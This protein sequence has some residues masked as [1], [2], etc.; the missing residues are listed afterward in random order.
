MTFLT[1]FA[2]SGY[3]K[4][5]HGGG[6]FGFS[7]HNSFY[8]DKNV[9]IYSASNGNDGN[10]HEVL[11]NHIADLALGLQPILNDTTLCTFP[12]PWGGDSKDQEDPRKHRTNHKQRKESRRHRPYNEIR[13]PVMDNDV[14][15]TPS[16]QWHEPFVGTF[17]HKTFGNMTVFYNSG[18]PN[19]L[20]YT[21]GRFG[22]GTLTRRG[23][24]TFNIIYGGMLSYSSTD[25]TL[26]F[27]KEEG[28]LYQEL[29]HQDYQWDRPPVFTRGLQWDPR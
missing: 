21:I 22:E 10:L 26:W 14:I 13:E 19:V 5:S 25:S 23:P 27:Q 20:Q 11:H 4:Y 17:G 9:G 1:F 24:V 8:P 2:F 6:W 18:D 15:K 12:R 29:V 16:L 3:R 7:S 28:G